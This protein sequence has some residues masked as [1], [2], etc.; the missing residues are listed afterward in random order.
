[1]VHRFAAPYFLRNLNN[2]PKMTDLDALNIAVK[3]VA[4]YSAR[5]PR[6]SHVTISQ[7]AEMLDCSRPTVRK[8]LLHSRIKL[9]AAG[10]IPIEAVDRLLASNS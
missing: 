10:A 7:A 5:H 9:N 4:I 6:P 3:A 8:L 1:M 2:G